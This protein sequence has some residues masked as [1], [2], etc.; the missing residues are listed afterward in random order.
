ME[1]RADSSFHHLVAA[2][3][4]TTGF[5]LAGATIHG[6]LQDAHGSDDLTRG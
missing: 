2:K 3:V 1:E 5:L 6:S 4:M